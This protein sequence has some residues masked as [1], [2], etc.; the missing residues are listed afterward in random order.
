ME[1][2]CPTWRTASSGP[3]TALHLELAFYPRTPIMDGYASEPSC[4]FERACFRSDTVRNLGVSSWLIMNSLE[5]MTWSVDIYRRRTVFGNMQSPFEQPMTLVNL[6]VLFETIYIWRQT[7]RL[8][9]FI[10]R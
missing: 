9:E 6:M 10:S 5:S 4:G 3:R 1:A 8:P 2:R 7:L